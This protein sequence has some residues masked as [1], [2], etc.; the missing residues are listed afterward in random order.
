MPKKRI[1]EELV[2]LESHLNAFYSNLA[3]GETVGR[4]LDFLLQ[5]MN[6][7]EYNI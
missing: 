5:E 2:R 7:K 4:K 1:D 6:R 3:S